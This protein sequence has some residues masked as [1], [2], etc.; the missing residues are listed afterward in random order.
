MK[1]NFAVIV[2][3]CIFLK[4]KRN[5]IRFVTLTLVVLRLEK[6]SHCWRMVLFHCGRISNYYS[7][8][9]HQ[10]LLLWRRYLYQVFS[11]SICLEH[12]GLGIWGLR[13]SSILEGEIRILCFVL[14][15]VYTVNIY[16]CWYFEKNTRKENHLKSHY[17]ESTTVDFLVLFTGFFCFLGF[18][19]S[20]VY[21]A[22]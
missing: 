21:Y 19:F 3:W 18:F 7:P 8:C 1:W 10:F 6:H 22:C 16:L 11:L 5:V 14:F 15:S 13:V 12:F 4:I 9:I 17:L 2:S 20:I